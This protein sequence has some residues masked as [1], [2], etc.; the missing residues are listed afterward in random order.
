M[1]HFKCLE[2]LFSLFIA[3]DWSTMNSAQKGSYGERLAL[4]YCRKHLGFKLITKNW[5]FGK[6]EIDLICLDG[7]VL[8]FIE[9]RVRHEAALVSGVNSINTKKKSAVRKCAKAYLKKL[10]SQPPTYRFDVISLAYGASK[11]LK[12]KHYP[13]VDLF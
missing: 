4:R 5:H 2:R 12:I 1:I 11:S 13:N 9:V 3:K 10:S 6:N 8:V 7:Q